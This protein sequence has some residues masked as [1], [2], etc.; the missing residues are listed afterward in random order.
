MIPTLLPE[1]HPGNI[2]VRNANVDIG[3]LDFGQTKRFTNERRMKFVALVDAMA[4]KDTAAIAQGLEGLDIKV[5]PKRGK[6][7]RARHTKKHLTFEE[8][9]AYTMF[10]TASV[11]GVS[12]NPFAADSA[13]SEGSVT[14]MPKDLF[15]LLRTIQ[16]LKG[17]CSATFNSDY[18]LI[19]SWGE[20]A[21]AELR[22]R[23]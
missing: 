7:S 4:R 6:K 1:G 11:P 12:D 9:L 14:N 2:L 21:R 23:R 10:D 19:S 15:F 13:L 22:L 17:L 8:K 5:L 16:I 3:L 18:S 20:I